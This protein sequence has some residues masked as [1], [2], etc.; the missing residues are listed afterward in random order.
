M[1]I[2]QDILIDFSGP[3]RPW[4]AMQHMHEKDI[5]NPL[6]EQ[7]QRMQENQIFQNL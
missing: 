4:Y 1:T 5:L 2:D 7:P 3:L 6:I